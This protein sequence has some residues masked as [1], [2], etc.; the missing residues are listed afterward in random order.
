M[1]I[2]MVPRRRKSFME[3]TPER[4]WVRRRGTHARSIPLM[5]GARRHS[6]ALVV[7]YRTVRRD[8]TI[9]DGESNGR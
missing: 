2:L 8:W 4:P 6:I 3:R 1:I 5:V 9:V 7:G